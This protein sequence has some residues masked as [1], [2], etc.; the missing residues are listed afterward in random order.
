MNV[1]FLHLA[2]KRGPA[3]AEQGRGLRDIAVGAR[4]HAPQR[5]TLR[6]REVGTAV[7]ALFLQDIRGRETLRDAGI[8]QLQRKTSG[9]GRAEHEI[10]LIHG[11][12]RKRRPEPTWHDDDACPRKG[13]AE[14]IALDALRRVLHRLG[15]KRKG[16]LVDVVAAG[17]N[18]ERTRH[19]AGMIANGS[20]GAAQFRIRREE[21][22]VTIDNHR[23][24][25]D[26]RGAYAVC[27]NAL[28]APDG[29]GPE[30]ERP[31]IAIIAGRASPLQRNALSI[32][33]E[34]AAAGS[35]DTVENSVKFVGA[36]SNQASGTFTGAPKLRLAEKDRL[37]IFFRC[38]TV[39]DHAATPRGD[40]RRTCGCGTVACG[41]IHAFRMGDVCRHALLPKLL[42]DGALEASM[43]Q[44]KTS[45]P[46]SEAQLTVRP[47]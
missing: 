34:Q 10:V 8:V 2:M 14:Q 29:A 36:F 4:Q 19:P 21:M 3:D 47:P 11:E 26:E 1:E 44:Q 40:N 35:P 32:G 37:A 41:F 33:Q 38:K 28:F 46:A 15:D 45:R 42:G 22:L 24:L 9:A 43:F 17:G 20:R 6:F 18:I 27:A 25:V 7:M 12:Q 31:E 39:L 30:A 23:T 13:T 16:H 5:R